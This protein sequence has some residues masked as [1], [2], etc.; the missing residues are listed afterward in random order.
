MSVIAVS[1][2]CCL[3]INEYVGHI[4]IYHRTRERRKRFIQESCRAFAGCLSFM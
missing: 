4:A 3:D 2:F 1:F